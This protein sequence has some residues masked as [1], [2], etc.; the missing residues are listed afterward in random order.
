MKLS[1]VSHRLVALGLGLLLFDAPG[2][3]AEPGFRRFADTISPDG[4]YVLAWG[5]DEDKDRPEKLREWPPGSDSIED[6]A[7]NYL[8][9]AK[10]SRVLTIIPE[11]DHWV[12]ADGR[13]KQ[14]SGLAVG[15]S[16]DSQRALAIYEGR[17]RDES[18]LWI[19]PKRRAFL[20]MA[21]QLIEAYDRFLAKKEKT[22]IADFDDFGILSFSM[23]ALLPDGVLV[24][25]ARAQQMIN[26]PPT[27]SY[28]L[29]LQVKTVGEE[30]KCTLISGRKIPEPADDD[31]V[32][33]ELNKVYQQLRAKL[34]EAG[35]AA[36]KEKQ[37]LWLKQRE[38]LV[39]SKRTFFTRLRTAYLRA[40]AEN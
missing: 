17:W 8:I 23:P 7:A 14:F 21:P 31:K 37:L 20:E 29:K 26:R 22:K 2:A 30:V 13:F 34:N 38:A 39:E 10:Q 18:I 25:D 24:I 12:T 3:A 28:R 33:D 1:A 9:D 35:R 27:Y 11:R 6:S 32:E 15:W 4:V 16:E 36:L 40:R 5:R 19:D